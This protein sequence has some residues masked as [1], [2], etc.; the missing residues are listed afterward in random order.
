MKT[1][2]KLLS[3]LPVLLLLSL[4]AACNRAGRVFGPKDEGGFYLVIAVKADASQLDQSIQQTI[5]VMQKRCEQMGIYCKGQR[6]GDDKSNQIMLRVSSPHDPERIKSVLLSQGLELRA[7]VSPPSPAA[8]QTYPT[9]AEAEAA[10]GTDKDVLP[11]LE[12]EEGAEPHPQKFVVVERT[13]IV[14]GQDIRDAKADNVMGGDNNYQVNFRLTPAGAQRFGSWTGANINRYLAVV[15]NKQVRS[16]AFIKSQ[17][18]DS[19]QIT[20]R[21]TRE[22]AE[23]A[24]L[25]LMS[26]NLPAPIEALEEGTYKP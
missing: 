4:V 26:G 15:L 10:A 8:L 16:V 19:A 25:V 17:I 18:F 23:D 20:G 12:R 1:S 5:A 7:A 14:T 9:Q 22:Q 21:F 2:H 6:H 24:A 3:L 13:P 11:Y